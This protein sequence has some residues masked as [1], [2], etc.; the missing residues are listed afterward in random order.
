MLESWA[1]PEVGEGV[2]SES[3]EKWPERRRRLEEPD[4]VQ[5]RASASS[6]SDSSWSEGARDLREL[7]AEGEQGK[8]W[9]GEVERE[10]EGAEAEERKK[11][12]MRSW[13]RSS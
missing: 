1:D 4:E 9:E 7:A 10:E 11:S 2:N 8:R 12:E 13:E 3:D 5:L 6:S